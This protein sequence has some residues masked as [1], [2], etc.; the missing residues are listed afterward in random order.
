MSAILNCRR[1]DSDDD[2]AQ[3][4]LFFL[5]RRREL[6]PSFT[7]VDVMSLVY[8]YI[9]EGRLILVTDEEGTTVAISAYYRGTPALAYSDRETVAFI[10]NALVAPAYRG[11]RAFVRGFQ[12]LL[13]LITADNPQIR[14]IRFVALSDNAY[15]R[16]LYSKFADYSH[17]EEGSIGMEDH[18]CVETDRLKAYLDR[19]ARP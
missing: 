3:A 19:F 1:C 10:D 15:L 9:T 14:E 2:Y 11:S 17:S 5:D 12:S 7:V 16:A 6:H 4:S 18:Y 8:S 13:R